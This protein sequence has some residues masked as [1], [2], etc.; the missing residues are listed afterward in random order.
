MFSTLRK[1]AMG[2][3][4]ASALIAPLAAHADPD[5]GLPVSDTITVA[6]T[7]MISPGFPCPAVAPGCVIDLDFTAVIVGDETPLPPPLVLPIVTC[8]FHGTD[9]G[10]TLTFGNGSGTVTCDDGTTASVTFSRIGVVVTLGGIVYIHG[11]PHVITAGALVFVP[12]DPTGSK[13]AVA[14]EV[15]LADA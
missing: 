7:G 2:A 14:G 3:A 13:F 4:L 6:G 10:G 9:V 11:V 12:L 1:A 8:H 5:D 15:V